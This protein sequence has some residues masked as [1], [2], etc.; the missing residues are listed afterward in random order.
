MTPVNIQALDQNIQ[1]NKKI[2]SLGQAVH[3]LRA[4]RDFKEIF[5]EGYFKHEAL[6]L[7]TLL[8]HPAMQTPEHQKSILTQMTAISAVD[9]YLTEVLR[10]ASLAESNIAADEQTRE[11]VLAE[12]DDA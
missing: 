5:I 7:V 8:S 3:R 6:R 1:E 4:N 10:Q 2:A 9:Q 12:G 11:E